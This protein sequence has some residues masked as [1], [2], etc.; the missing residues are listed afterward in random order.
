MLP[1][2]HFITFQLQQSPFHSSHGLKFHLVSPQTITLSFF[3][4]TVYFQ[5]LI[6]V[7]LCRTNLTS[8][9]EKLLNVQTQDKISYSVPLSTALNQEKANLLKALSQNED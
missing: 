8:E 3:F 9:I 2:S 1:P 4:Q 7:E 5:K 6:G